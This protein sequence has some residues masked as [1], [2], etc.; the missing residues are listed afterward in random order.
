MRLTVVPSLEFLRG[1]D[2]PLCEVARRRR[3]QPLEHVEGA[4][5]APHRHEVRI[6][7][8]VEAGLGAAGVR[9]VVL[10]GAHH[11]LDLVA[12]ERGVVGGD[13]GPEAGDLEDHLR[14]EEAQELEIAAG[15]VVLPHVVGDR[16]V[17]VSL[18]VRG[19]G[20]PVTRCR[21]EVHRLRLL[22]PVARA[23][24]REHR[25]V[26]SGR[27]RT[28]AGLVH[29][30]IAVEQER[31]R[32]LREPQAEQRD[33][34]YLVPEHVTAVRLAV[35]PPG[36]HADVEA[37]RVVRHRLH[38]VEELKVQHLNEPVVRTH[39]DVGAVPEM[40]PRHHVALE[41]P[42]EVAGDVHHPVAGFVAGLAD[43][44]VA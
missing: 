5:Q 30:P 18:P 4:A 10:V 3:W 37:Y 17:D 16:G 25:S 43:P 11:T 22:A 28:A 24:P 31:A 20:K 33:H 23:L 2:Q 29:A 14:P 7:V 1:D 40:T 35:Q 44:G 38:Q 36:R 12:V 21:V 9:L 32:Q 8:V 34:E 42:V 26:V 13:A 6:R 41:K 19:V 15:E 39:L 27:G